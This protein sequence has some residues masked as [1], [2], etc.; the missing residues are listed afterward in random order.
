MIEDLLTAFP[1]FDH[2]E[3][4]KFVEVAKNDHRT[5]GHWLFV[6]GSISVFHRVKQCDEIWAIHAGRLTLHV[7][8]PAGKHRVL[9]LGLAVAA[10]ERPM[11]V[12]PAGH[13]QAAELPAGAAYAF[14]SNV[15]APGFSYAGLEL[16]RRA[17]LCR[18]H[19]QHTGLITRLTR[20]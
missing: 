17:D 9:Q 10:G 5:V 4:M 18:A 8:E 13:W 7:V 15:C 19:P 12:V 20:G 2:P 6:P 11:A 14:G 16:A 3:G 1:W